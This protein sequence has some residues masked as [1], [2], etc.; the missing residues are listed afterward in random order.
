M[1]VVNLSVSVWLRETQALVFGVETGAGFMALC[2]AFVLL[3]SERR[4]KVPVCALQGLVC[5]RVCV[6]VCVCRLCVVCC[7]WHLALNCSLALA[8]ACCM[9]LD[10]G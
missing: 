8:L 1:W 7:A 4:A 10:V 6:C 5:A 2:Q 9:M 3:V